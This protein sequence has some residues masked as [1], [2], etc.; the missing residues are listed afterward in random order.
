MQGTG[1]KRL[2]RLTTAIGMLG[3]AACTANGGLGDGGGVNPGT[4]DGTGGDCLLS[5]GGLCVIG[6][7]GT[8][9]PDHTCTQVPPGGAALTVA[10]AGLLCT[11]TDPLSPALNTCDVLDAP[12][13]VDGSYD[14]PARVQYVVGAVDPLLGGNISLTVDLPV[15]V[16]AG[17]VAAFLVQYPG[18]LV[19]ASVIR[20]LTVTT[21]LAGVEQESNTYDTVLDL[22]V[23]GLMGASEKV[24]VGFPNTQPYNRITLTV[25]AFAASADVFNAVDVFEA[26]LNARPNA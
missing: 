5:V 25:D 4:G 26:C 24:L 21:A 23:L 12:L 16:N 13:M 6:G 19:D 10:E 22:D 18:G 3:L 20:G 9:L 1:M 15:V 17:Q 2:A 11:L 8:E 7:P 14:T